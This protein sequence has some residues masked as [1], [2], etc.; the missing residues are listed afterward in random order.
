[1]NIEMYYDQH[2]PFV[3]YWIPLSVKWKLKKSTTL[4]Y[5]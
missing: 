5:Y 1:M 4:I 2:E 3:T